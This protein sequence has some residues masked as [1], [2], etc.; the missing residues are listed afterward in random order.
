MCNYINQYNLPE[1]SQCEGEICLLQVLKVSTNVCKSAF[2]EKA[3]WTSPMLLET[4]FT[5]NF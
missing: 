5:K 2:A 4:S 1:V 3:C